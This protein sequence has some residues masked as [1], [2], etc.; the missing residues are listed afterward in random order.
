[1]FRKDTQCSF[2]S[3]PAPNFFHVFV[4][5]HYLDGRV[6]LYCL[7]L[8]TSSGFGERGLC[9]ADDRS[10]DSCVS[11]RLNRFFYFIW[12]VE[13]LSFDFFRNLCHIRQ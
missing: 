1:M 4:V 9:F 3:S 6:G 13:G 11:Y 8:G 2:V 12:M 10:F 5:L 7:Y